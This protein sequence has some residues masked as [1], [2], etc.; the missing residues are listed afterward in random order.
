MLYPSTA[1]VI[2]F[3]EEVYTVNE[4]DGQV[5]VT[6]AVLGGQLSRTVEVELLTQDGSATG[7]HAEWTMVLVFQILILLLSSK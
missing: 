2:G 5:V 7:I 3:L 1:V 6:V 4:S